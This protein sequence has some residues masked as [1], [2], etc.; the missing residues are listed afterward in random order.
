VPLA[1]AQPGLSMNLLFGLGWIHRGHEALRAWDPSAPLTRVQDVNVS[2]GGPE[3]MM[4][5]LI[6]E[7]NLKALEAEIDN[8]D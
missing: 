3:E 6:R 8:S 5:A 1:I 2:L 4:H 7:L